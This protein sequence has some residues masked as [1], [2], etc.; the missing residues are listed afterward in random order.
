MLEW[1]LGSL[2]VALGAA[3]LG[4]GGSEGAAVE[5]ARIVFQVALAFFALSAVVRMV[6]GNG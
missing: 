2:I 5:L 3:I 6:R 1:G 4:F